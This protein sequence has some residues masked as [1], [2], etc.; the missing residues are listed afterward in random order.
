[1]KARGAPGTNPISLPN[2]AR[3]NGDA[4]AGKGRGCPIRWAAAARNQDIAS[5]GQSLPR[6]APVA[7]NL[8]IEDKVRPSSTRSHFTGNPSTQ[9]PSINTALFGI[10]V[11]RDRQPPDRRSVFTIKQ[12][13]RTRPAP[14]ARSQQGKADVQPLSARA[15]H[16]VCSRSHHQSSV[17]HP[18]RA[19][20]EH[21]L[22]LHRCQADHGED[23]SSPRSERDR[24]RVAY[25]YP[26][27]PSGLMDDQTRK[28]RS[29]GEERRLTWRRINGRD[30][31]RTSFLRG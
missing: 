6:P 5:G 17:R 7:R 18:Y 9:Q 15:I 16:Q 23:V 11:I 31:S 27:S 2:E 20:G 26:A 8:V 3:Q 28:V 10:R 12:P 13:K 24:P 25:Y 30:V 1:M 29:R 4:K 19:A 22:S 14:F 21:L